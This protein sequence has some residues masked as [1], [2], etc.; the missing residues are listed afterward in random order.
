MKTVVVKETRD[1]TFV[2]W[3][4]CPMSE[5]YTDAL[6][7]HPDGARDCPGCSSEKCPLQKEPITIRLAGEKSEC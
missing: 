3:A 1:C 4:Y 6:C 7:T 2:E 5:S